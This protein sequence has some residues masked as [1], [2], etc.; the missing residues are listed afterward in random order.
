MTEKELKIFE[1]YLPEPTV[2]YCSRLWSHHK[3]SLKI[4]KPRSSKLGDYCFCRR[5]GHSISVNSNLNRYSFLITYLHEVAHLLVQKSN[6]RRK[7]PHGK[8]WKDA[9]RGLLVPVMNEQVFP[10]DILSALNIYYTN[11]AASTGSHSVLS[12]ALRLYDEQLEG[13]AQLAFLDENEVFQLNGRI[14]SKGPMRRTRYFCKE[15]TTGKNYIILGRA[16]VKKIG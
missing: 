12:Q 1:K 11:P 6:I 4:T 2:Q 8:E 13:F 16:L 5:N 9:F 3:F 7:L 10:Y 14:F 15:I